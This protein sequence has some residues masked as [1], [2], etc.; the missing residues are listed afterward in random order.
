[1]CYLTLD[2]YRLDVK[3]TMAVFA[4]LGF[5]SVTAIDTEMT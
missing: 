1:M 3:F 2:L 4:I 5:I